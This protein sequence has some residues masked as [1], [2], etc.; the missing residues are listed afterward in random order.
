MIVNLPRV[1]RPGAAA[2]GSSP[3][4]EDVL[5]VAQ[6]RLLR[7]RHQQA[8]DVVADAGEVLHLG[9]G[10]VGC[11][12]VLEALLVGL[13]TGHIEAPAFGGGVH[14]DELLVVHDD[15]VDAVRAVRPVL[16]QDFDA[17]VLQ[18]RADCLM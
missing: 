16:L 6:E 15:E 2:L 14:E 3:V 8:H 9:L 17:P 13:L 1:R 4:V 5:V 7:A 12:D 18:V 11:S 10:E